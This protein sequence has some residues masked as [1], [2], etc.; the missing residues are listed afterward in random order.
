M[1]IK[2]RER[3]NVNLSDVAKHIQDKWNK[4]NTFKKSVEKR[5]DGPQGSDA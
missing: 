2:F 1:S 5:D 3:K 4:E